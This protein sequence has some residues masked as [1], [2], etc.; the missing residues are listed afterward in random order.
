MS[1]EFDPDS[2]HNDQTSDINIKVVGVGSFGSSSLNYMIEKKIAKV[3]CITVHSDP[4]ALKESK[5]PVKVLVGNQFMNENDS[6]KKS[7]HRVMEKILNRR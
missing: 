4:Q 2:F 7:E 1:F 6:K 5:A 3:T